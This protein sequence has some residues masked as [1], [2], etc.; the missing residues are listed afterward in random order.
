MP[1]L[2]VSPL[3]AHHLL[4]TVPTLRLQS[5]CVLGLVGA[6]CE[7]SSVL[8]ARQLRCRCQLSPSLPFPRV[9]SVSGERE[10]VTRCTPSTW[11]VLRTTV[12]HVCPRL[13]L[14]WVSATPPPPPPRVS[15]PLLQPPPLPW[16]RSRG[17]RRNQDQPNSGSPMSIDCGEGQ[18]GPAT[19]SHPSVPFVR[20]P[21]G[22]AEEEDMTRLALRIPKNG[23][24]NGY[25][26]CSLT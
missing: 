22:T 4:R 16:R 9:M 25:A 14:L 17:L 1:E 20:W 24:T 6:Q 12:L 23:S 13:F 5:L 21:A 8:P 15:P 7:R 3:Q 10:C 11:P 18:R 26:V 2:L 19:F